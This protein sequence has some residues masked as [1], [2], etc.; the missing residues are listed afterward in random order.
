MKFNKGLVALASTLA[1]A[2]A[3]GVAA[4][5][6]N[7]PFKR[8]A[9]AETSLSTPYSI[10]LD[11]DWGYN[12]ESVKDIT[13]RLNNNFTI[14]FSNDGDN[15]NSATSNTAFS[16]TSNG[17][18]IYNVT[19]L[20]GVSE[21]Y[22]KG[23]SSNSN[24]Y[25]TI[26]THYYRQT[27]CVDDSVTVEGTLNN[28]I[29][30]EPTKYFTIKF[31]G[32]VSIE[33]IEIGYTCSVPDDPNLFMKSGGQNTDGN[34]LF[35]SMTGLQ[36]N[37]PVGTPV[38]VEM[39]VS[40][41]GT[42]DNV[43][44]E[45]YWVNNVWSTSGGESD[46]D[47]TSI[48]TIIIDGSEGWHHIS[49][50]ATIRNFPNLT[51]NTKYVTQDTSEF[52]NAVYLIAITHG[53]LDSFNYKNVEITQ[54][55]L[56][57]AGDNGNNADKYYQSIT[58]LE[59]DLEVG[60]KVI[61]EMDVYVT[62]TYNSYSDIF[63]ADS[64]YSTAGGELNGKTTI[65]SIINN[66][67]TGWHHVSFNATVRNFSALRRNSSYP[68][69][70]TSS[71]GNAVYL[72]SM[73]KSA[74]AFS[75]KD[76][77]FNPYKSLIP[78]GDNGNSND[79][80]YQSIACLSTDFVVGTQVTID[81]DVYV[82]GTYNSYSDIFVADSVYS[83][84]G[85]E[86]N[87]KTTITSIINNGET[88]WHH[89]SFNATVRNFSALRRNSS[90][91]V[92][93]TSDYGNGVYLLSMNKSADSFNYANVEIA[94]IAKSGG[95][96]SKG[97]G[98]YQSI[99]GLSTDLAVDTD[100][101]VEMDIKI[102]G[103][104]NEWSAFLW[105]NSIYS[106]NARND[107]PS[108]A[109]LDLSDTTNWQH[110]TFN[111]TVR[112]FSL[113]RFSVEYTETSTTE[114]GNAVYL[115]TQNKSA[116]AF[117]YKN[118]SVAT[119]VQRSKIVIPNSEINDSSS[120][121]C[122][123]AN[124][125]KDCL[126]ESDINLEIV[127][128]VTPTAEYEIVLGSTNRFASTINNPESYKLVKHQN[129][130]HIDA[131]NKR[132][133]IYGVYAWLESVGF[134]FYTKDV[135][136]APNKSE[137]KITNINETHHQSFEYREL[138]Y[139]DSYDVDW[140]VSQGLNGLVGRTETNNNIK[141]EQYG[142][143]FGYI[144][145]NANVHTLIGNSSNTGT[146][147]INQV[148]LDIN[149]NYYHPEYFS[150]DKNG[151]PYVTSSAN[152]NYKNAQV[153]FS[154]E[155]ALNLA[156][157]YL[158]YKIQ[159]YKA[160]I[161][162]PGINGTYDGQSSRYLVSL[163][164]NDNICHCDDCEAQYAQYGVSGTWLRWVN[165]LARHVK[166]SGHNDIQIET[167]AYHE[168]KE[169][170]LGGIVP[171][172]N[173]TIR[174]CS[175][176]GGCIADRNNSLDLEEEQAL[177]DGW[178]DICDSV[179]VYYYSN[180]YRNYMNVYPNFDDIYYNLK[181]L[182]EVGVK[183][184]YVEGFL[185]NNGEFGELRSFLIAKMLQNPAMS[186]SEYTSLI[187]DFCNCYYGAAGQYILSYISEAKNNLT[188]EIRSSADYDAGKQ[189]SFTPIFKNNCESYWDAAENAVSGDSILL[190]RV[191]KSRLHWTFT[192]LMN[193]ESSY[194]TSDYETA[195]YAL[196]NK[197]NNLNVKCVRGNASIGIS[198]QH[199]LTQYRGVNPQNWDV[200]TNWYGE[201]AD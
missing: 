79:R 61:V 122:H 25:L 95:A 165:E 166:T 189:F 31:E 75:Y 33:S 123:A 172:D 63:V 94:A 76:F 74:D 178:T 5:N 187:N 98:F 7:S 101:I 156:K 112:N 38:T 107:A 114:F 145:S 192:M 83:T 136:K 139:K 9:F 14:G 100:V 111:A 164:D 177:L 47:R 110:I 191:Q 137:I 157:T 140:S 198:N 134:D 168:T 56:T 185:R 117:M 77:T 57:P 133:I 90:Y 135:F 23:T 18:Y 131:M 167:L 174:F 161:Y 144:N 147:L 86:L 154:S 3:V 162:A 127:S 16:T 55:A 15:F 8:T 82:T 64:V 78:S 141:E 201:V 59:T 102:T 183:G 150:V 146:A 36:S 124:I 50:E 97:N 87:G 149:G 66:G 109:S 173:V 200:Q 73:N 186:Y 4:I 115:I 182:E 67:E 120:P 116:D 45:I 108:I 35:Q 119:D 71:Y 118:V 91:P 113:L 2:L 17:E 13:S 84:A 181:Y 130:L 169:L 126:S 190:N 1:T 103:T 32:T 81:M 21:V 159:N 158:I 68:V 171:E 52:G 125:L 51:Y 37:L 197:M 179:Y 188:G 54:N 20:N 41:T 70:D 138:V 49:F 160:G 39:D 151:D 155:G 142:G 153:C 85:G 176:F 106:N 46:K 152:D 24:A 28:I 48:K 27:E 34:G 132:G 148:H 62:G 44:C 19:V 104:F 88:G 163:M 60:T 96:N 180:N 89:V 195:T 12:K 128:D 30:F 80:Y 40:V 42:F 143:Y 6:N 194:S 199:G 10:L 43:S 196:A 11:H 193:Y 184:V 92:A 72:L 121:T 99:A 58:A 69:F 175:D 93:N 22:V 29:S 105:V 65:T 26:Y 170:P 129:S 53:T